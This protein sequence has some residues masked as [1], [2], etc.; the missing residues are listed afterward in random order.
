M[1][2]TCMST[3][4]LQR[5]ILI[6]HMHSHLSDLGFEKVNVKCFTCFYEQLRTIEFV[7]LSSESKSPTFW[8]M[9][10]CKA[11]PQSL[12][13]IN[14]H[15]FTK[16]GIWDSSLAPGCEANKLLPVFC[17]KSLSNSLQTVLERL[18]LVHL[19]CNDGIVTSQ[20]QHFRFSFLKICV[21]FYKHLKSPAVRVT[22]HAQTA[23]EKMTMHVCQTA[24]SSTRPII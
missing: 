4:V 15:V 6:L 21:N 8:E 2:S 1:F 20:L 7:Q 24:Q 14:T 5:T 3:I 12:Q 17:P 22:I 19:T 9:L 13:K 23:S 11:N 18:Y 16:I 10:A